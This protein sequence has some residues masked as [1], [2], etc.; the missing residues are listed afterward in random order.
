MELFSLREIYRIC[1]RHRGPGP[2]APAHESTDFI[3]RQSFT[4]GSTTQIESSKPV[5]QLLIL[6]VHRWSDGWGGWLRPGAAP[7]RARGGA[8]RPSAVARRS[9]SFLELWW[10]VFDVVCSYGITTTR[11]HML[12][13]TLIG[14]ERQRSPAMVRWLGRCLSTVRAASGEASWWGHQ[15]RQRNGYSY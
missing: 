14:G 8:S 12:M 2:P 15:P 9:L 11:G 7:A 1:P 3:K 5:F 13:L 4:S 10:L 6:A